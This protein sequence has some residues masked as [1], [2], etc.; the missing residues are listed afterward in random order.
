MS[1]AND[2]IQQKTASKGRFLLLALRRGLKRIWTLIKFFFWIAFAL[3]V[4]WMALLALIYYMHLH[5]FGHSRFNQTEWIAE[6]EK[7]SN[8]E[9]CSMSGTVMRDIVLVGMTRLEVEEKIGAGTLYS[10]DRTGDGTLVYNYY[11]GWCSP[12]AWDPYSML[13]YYRNDIVTHVY[14]HQH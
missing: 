13:V 8:A 9:R 14:G 12:M 11:L 1:I 4:C 2:P 3:F 6:G 5:P 7:G 10:P